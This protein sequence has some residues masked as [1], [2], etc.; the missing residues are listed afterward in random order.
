MTNTTITPLDS[1]PVQTDPID[2]AIAELADASLA[3]HVI[4]DGSCKGMAS[5]TIAPV[6]TLAR[7]A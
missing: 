7:A 6:E 3:D 1:H 2:A 5:C 4:C